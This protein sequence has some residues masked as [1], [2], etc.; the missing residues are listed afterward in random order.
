MKRKSD[1]FAQ[2]KEEDTSEEDVPKTVDPPK[3]LPQ[4]KKETV[5]PDSMRIKRGVI[6]S[7]DEDDK[8][9]VKPKTSRKPKAELVDDILD[10]ERSVRAIM[11]IDDC[12]FNPF[13]LFQFEE[14]TNA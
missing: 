3:A 10:P 11:D 2:K 13:W 9:V 5:E 6:L 8:A 4:A 7:D 1:V 14:C 12:M